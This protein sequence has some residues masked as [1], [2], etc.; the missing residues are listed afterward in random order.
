M[1]RPTGIIKSY[2][3]GEGRGGGRQLLCIKHVG[4]LQES[5]KAG[6]VK[7]GGKCHSE[8]SAMKLEL[9]RERDREEIVRL[10]FGGE[11]VR[12]SR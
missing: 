7:W 2:S 9:E 6:G 10:L 11:S 4:G 12:L 3:G 1:N 8:E 5:W